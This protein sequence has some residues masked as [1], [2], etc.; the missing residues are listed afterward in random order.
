L[1]DFQ[2]IAGPGSGDGLAR[3]MERVSTPQT[4]RGWEFY[5]GSGRIGTG[6]WNHFPASRMPEVHKAAAAWR[7]RLSGVS[8]PWLCW[9][10]DP[11]WCLI[12]QQLVAAVGWTPVVGTDGS[13]R[14]TVIDGGIYIDFNEQLRLPGMWMHFPLE[15]AHLYADR[16]AFWHSDV[17]PPI[18]CMR[19]IAR[20]FEAVRDGELLVTEK[21][22]GLLYMIRRLLRGKRIRDVSGWTE[23][24]GC[25]TRGA[26]ESQFQHGCGW[27]RGL[28]K[29][30]NAKPEVVRLNPHWEHGI[31][32]RYWQRIFHG[33]VMPLR[34]DVAPYH[35]SRAGRPQKKYRRVLVENQQTG[36]KVS[37][38]N[39]N[40]RLEDIVPTL[41]AEVRLQ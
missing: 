29:H 15:F 38:L 37:E 13:N 3:E 8:R 41:G 12:Q 30:P 7:E 18:D 33:R 31:G 28:A 19:S 40:Y 32:I 35:Y 6:D 4:D 34:T 10:I 17:L 21:K 23:I 24:A 39:S 20:E 22:V 1:A 16:L 11:Q 2:R 25:T 27:W 9:S 14:P 5:R 26:S 36:S